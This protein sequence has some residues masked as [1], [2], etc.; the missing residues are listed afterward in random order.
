MTEQHVP[1]ALVTG[2]SRGLGRAL[3]DQL[4]RDGWRVVVDARHAADLTFDAPA[5]TA[6]P[7]DVTDPAHRR[8]LVEV[9]DGL[10]GLD[11]LVNNASL[12]GPSPQPELVD[13]PLDVLTEVLA[14]NVLAPLALLQ[15]LH[16]LLRQGAR[17]IDVSS[18][19]AVEAMAGWGGYGASKAALDHLTA[20]L[21]VEAP[22]L[23]VY[24]VDPG[25]MRT[26][27]HQEAFPGEDIGDRPLPETVVPALR[28]LVDGTLPSGRY[29]AAD[30]VVAS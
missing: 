17:V 30:L 14:V 19:A 28:A 23:R 16:P 11:L 7:G 9:V 29:R 10:G 27:M 13:Y 21:A 26:V 12:L 8:R 20:V 18:D 6:V 5:V 4:V 24:A 1:T 15:A 22:Q 25:D 2:A 3:T